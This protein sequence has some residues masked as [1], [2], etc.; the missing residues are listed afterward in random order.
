VPEQGYLPEQ[1]RSLNRK[2]ISEKDDRPNRRKAMSEQGAL[3]KQDGCLIRKVVS[4]QES[5]L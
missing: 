3:S 1:D 2:D 4:E 5:C